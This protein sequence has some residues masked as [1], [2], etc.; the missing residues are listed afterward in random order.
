MISLFLLLFKKDY[1][2]AMLRRSTWF[3]AGLS[4]KRIHKDKRARKHLF[5]VL[6]AALAPA[7]V[8][9]YLMWMIG[10][11]A[12]FF[13]LPALIIVGLWRWNS[14]RQS[15]QPTRITPAPASVA[16]RELTAEESN[17]LRQYCSE[18]ALVLA[19]MVDRAGSEQFLKQQEIP[20]GIEITTRRRHIDMLKSS[21]LWERISASDREAVLLPDG[22]WEWALINQISVRLELVRL[23]RWILRIDAYLPLVGKQLRG[24]YGVAHELVVSPD[25][26]TTTNLI[27]REDLET[28][29]QSARTIFLRC[30]AEAIHR[31][32]HLPQN[33]EDAQ[34]AKSVAEELGGKQDK[35]FLLGSVLVSEAREE[36]LRWA[37]TLSHL[38]MEFL[39]HV[40]SLFDNPQLPD[41]P[42]AWIQ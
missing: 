8:L 34:W 3:E 37:S 27:R 20:D 42:F 33:E 38:R 41:P 23:L 22:H 36:D 12:V 31:G 14:A 11:G 10:S 32:Y 25:K 13:L 17:S 1:W 40:L 15:Q 19:L 21:G 29:Y 30:L 4:L 6:L 26:L 28:G 5:R 24:D 39:R 16:H 2:R 7:L 35:D 18:Y 9:L